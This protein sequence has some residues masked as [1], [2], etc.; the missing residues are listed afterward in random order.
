MF[1]DFEVFQ[2]LSSRGVAFRVISTLNPDP[3]SSVLRVWS[4]GCEAK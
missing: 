4:F 2:G 3:K 1:E